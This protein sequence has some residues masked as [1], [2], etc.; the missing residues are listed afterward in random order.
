MPTTDSPIPPAHR[1][2]ASTLL[3]AVLVVSSLALGVGLRIQAMAEPV[4]LDELHTAWC[5]S[6]SPGVVSARATIGNQSPLFFWIEYP[7]YRGLGMNEFAL[8]FLPLVCSIALLLSIWWIV[9]EFS[10]SLTGAWLALSLAAI[11]DSFL[12]YA[13]EA[14]PYGMIQ[15]VAVWQSYWWIGVLRGSES[16][17]WPEICF[18]VASL[19]LFY[20][21][22]TTIVLLVVQLGTTFCWLAWQQRSGQQSAQRATTRRSLVVVSLIAI[23]CLPGLVQLTGIGRH[24]ADWQSMIAPNRYALLIVSQIIVYLAA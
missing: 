11:D 12:F 13:V 9:L 21:H 10:G 19:L 16:R 5:V 4:W 3:A 24:R 15:L 7:V 8:R 22:Y 18:V 23:A 17:R 20:L 2:R 1:S 6:D 14:R